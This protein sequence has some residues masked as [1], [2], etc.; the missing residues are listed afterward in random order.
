MSYEHK[1]NQYIKIID[2]TINI[3]INYE[4][5]FILKQNKRVQQCVKVRSNETI[6]M[7]N[8]TVMMMMLLNAQRTEIRIACR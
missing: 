5:M 7:K 3:V 4:C 1:I 8:K 6:F 2:K